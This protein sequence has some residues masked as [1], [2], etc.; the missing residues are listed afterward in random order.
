MHEFGEV[1]LSFGLN[2]LS[3]SNG[4]CGTAVVFLL[5]SVSESML[6]FIVKKSKG[7]L[8]LMLIIIDQISENLMLEFD[9]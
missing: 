9:S 5:V 4:R 8:V 2:C 1:C 6:C 3:V 7:N